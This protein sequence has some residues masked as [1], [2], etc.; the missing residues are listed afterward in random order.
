MWVYDSPIGELSIVP[1]SNGKY[2]LLF[3]SDIWEACDTPQA[4]A[5][6]VLQHVTG[7]PEWDSLAGLVD[8]V[9]DDLSGWEVT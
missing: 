7:C 2:G 6:N 9:P 5:D 3:G 8:G 4:Q 1:L